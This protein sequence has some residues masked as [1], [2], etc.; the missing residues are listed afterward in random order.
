[1]NALIVRRIEAAQ[2]E[3]H[4][5]WITSTKGKDL[6]GDRTW[7]PNG[8]RKKPPPVTPAE[9]QRWRALRRSG[10]NDTQIAREVGRSQAW[11]SRMLGSKGRP[12]RKR[13]TGSKAE[14]AREHTTKFRHRVRAARLALDEAL[15]R[16]DE[17]AA[18]V[19][20]EGLPPSALERLRQRAEQKGFRWPL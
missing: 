14:R 18:R 19:A 20:L 17:A 15:S 3:Q 4:E 10:L 9:L 5:Q 1:V 6:P 7:N 16:G 8:T 2:L 11:V 13:L 12:A